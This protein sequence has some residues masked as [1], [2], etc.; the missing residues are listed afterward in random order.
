MDVST[1]EDAH[2]AMVRLYATMPFRPNLVA[3]Y[4]LYFDALANREGASLLHCLAGKDRTGIAAALLHSLI[5]VHHDDLMAD[6]LLT[7]MA[8][9]VERRIAAG[10][11]VVRASFGPSMD[12]AAVRTL[13]SV[14]PD[15]L[16][17]AFTT[18]TE[19]HGSVEAYARDVLGVTPAMVAR[20]EERLLM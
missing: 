17:T 10:A 20:M 4:R 16:D 12:D 9:N 5:G 3:I 1:A 19:H 2:A 6:Y 7:N 15:F 13:M 8:G 11:K 18:I 14:H